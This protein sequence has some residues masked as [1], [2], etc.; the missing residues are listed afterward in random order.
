MD[1]WSA[2]VQAPT[3]V[4]H[5]ATEHPG[6]VTSALTRPAP[7]WMTERVSDSLTNEGGAV[8]PK[9]HYLTE[10]VKD[11]IWELRG[12]GLSDRE[13]GRRLGLLGGA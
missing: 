10:A 12:E 8:M 7:S 11:A 2:S 1:D 4:K 3:R 9:G 5:E 6:P 13:I